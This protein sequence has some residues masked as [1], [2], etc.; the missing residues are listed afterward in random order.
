MDRPKDVP[1]GSLLAV[2]AAAQ[3]STMGVLGHALMDFGIRPLT[4]VALRAALAFAVLA[5]LLALFGRQWLS[6]RRQ[7]LLFF[8]LYGVIG[9]TAGYSLF[10]IA[11]ERTGVAVSTI[12]LYTY[13]VIVTVLAVPLLGEAITPSKIVA[14]LLTLCGV[15]LVA[16]VLS[17]HAA[18]LDGQGVAAALLCAVAVASQSIFGKKGLRRYTSWTVMLYSLGFGAV[19]LMASQVILYGMPELNRP[20]AFWG[21]LAA[22][23]C[24][25]TLGAYLT[26]LFALTYIEASKASVIAAVEPVFAAVLAHTLFRETLSPVQLLGMALI[27]IG[28]LAVW[29][30]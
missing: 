10:F 30:R 18:R 17:R 9:V 25:S 26:Y 13:P 1:L 16:G 19:V 3:W 14:L 7:D 6:I 2:L 23:A 4:L 12:L 20:P 22:L 24:I 21:L 28:V 5:I 15:V 11:V 27:L 8:A 29:R